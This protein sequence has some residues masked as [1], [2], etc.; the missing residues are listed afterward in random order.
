[1]RRNQLKESDFSSD[2][3]LRRSFTQ[4]YGGYHPG[5]PVVIWLWDILQN[6]FSETEKKQFLKVVFMTSI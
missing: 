5:H 6:D 2:I 4:Y 3:F 1:M